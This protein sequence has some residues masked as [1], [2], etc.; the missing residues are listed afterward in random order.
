MH[1]SLQISDDVLEGIYLCKSG[2]DCVNSSLMGL[3]G[4]LL[5]IPS[6]GPN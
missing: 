1:N 5:P 6:H 3:L 4:A 2:V